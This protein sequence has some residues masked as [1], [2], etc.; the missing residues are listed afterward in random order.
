[1]RRLIEAVLWNVALAVVLLTIWC[2]LLW[3]LFLDD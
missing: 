3:W 2:T 1:M